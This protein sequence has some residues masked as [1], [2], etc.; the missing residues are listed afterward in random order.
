[1]A[2]GD[3]LLATLRDTALFAADAATAEALGPAA[4]RLAR[5][6]APSPGEVWCST[7]PAAGRTVGLTLAL[8]LDSVIDE[9]AEAR[10]FATCLMNTPGATTPSAFGEFGVYE[11]IRRDGRWRVTRELVRM[12]F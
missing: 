7:R 12:A 11:M 6:V 9:R 3:S 5:S 2:A 1:V 10:W 8:A 4:R